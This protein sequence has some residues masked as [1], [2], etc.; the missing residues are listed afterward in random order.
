MTNAGLC[1]GWGNL[2]VV[3]KTHNKIGLPQRG[4]LLF[5]NAG[6]GLTKK[7]KQRFFR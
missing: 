5:K 2:F 7:G 6:L 4:N 3:A 1:P